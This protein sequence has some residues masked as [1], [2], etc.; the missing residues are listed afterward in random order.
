MLA[1]ALT[2]LSMS[3]CAGISGGAP[4]AKFY[5]G[6]YEGSLIHNDNPYGDLLIEGMQITAGTDGVCTLE[7]VI[8]ATNRE[9]GMDHTSNT[10]N[11]WEG[12]GAIHDGVLQFS[13]VVTYGGDE[14]EKG[15]GSLQ[16]QGKEYILIFDGDKFR[17]NKD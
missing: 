5:T 3:G 8:N 13:Y 15:T 11:H 10:R 6:T 9:E 7:G 2:L 14:S 16:K 12:T 17:L 4:D 1:V